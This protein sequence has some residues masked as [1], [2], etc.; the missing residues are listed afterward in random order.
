MTTFCY[1][2]KDSRYGYDVVILR[3]LELAKGEARK[4]GKYTTVY[5][6]YWD[7]VDDF[8]TEKPCLEGKMTCSQILEKQAVICP[9]LNI[10]RLQLDLSLM[11]G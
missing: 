1:F 4:L 11:G 9:N 2:A 3:A 5:L 7:T 6:G 10:A 8:W